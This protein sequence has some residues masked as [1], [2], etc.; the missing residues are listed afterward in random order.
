M[1]FLRQDETQSITR[2]YPH[3]IGLRLRQGG[4]LGQVLFIHDY[5]V[6]LLSSKL[7]KK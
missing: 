1:A 7:P 5:S 4:D 2:R 3:F 6:F